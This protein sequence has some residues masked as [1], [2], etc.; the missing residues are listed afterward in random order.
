MTKWKE[1]IRRRLAGLNLAPA[2]EAEIVEELY[3][4]LK[5]RYRELRQGGATVEQADQAVRLELSDGRLLAHEL[6]R[7]EHAIPPEPVVFGS[8]S[9]KNMIA[10]LRQDLI[11]GF[12]V[13]RKSPGFTAIAI[14]TLALG[15]GAN[16]G[17]FSAVYNILLKP[18]PF[19]E[20]DRLVVLEESHGGEPM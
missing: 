15:I 11:Y 10:D 12:R 2:R 16:T 20:P 6:R 5:D 13:L 14:L 19:S 3:Q 8:S 7:V 1:E 4:H 9:G 18:L 17:I